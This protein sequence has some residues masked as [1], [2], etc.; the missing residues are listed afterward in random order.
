VVVK[1]VVVT[2]VVTRGDTTGG[3]VAAVAAPAAAAAAAWS[4]A[5]SIIL[6]GATSIG[7]IIW[8]GAIAWIGVTWAGMARVEK[9]GQVTVTGEVMVAGH[10]V[11]VTTRERLLTTG[12]SSQSVPEMSATRGWYVST[13]SLCN[14]KKQVHG[15]CDLARGG[16]V[17]AEAPS[18]PLQ[19]RDTCT[20]QRRIM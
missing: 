4:A 3:A 16:D 20:R 9:V 14:R 10:E 17:L 8:T 15:E 19:G 7:A 5:I 11:E 18:R 1:G 13:F 12:T 2:G 6:V